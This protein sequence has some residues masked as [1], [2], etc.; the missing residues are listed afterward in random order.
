M[1]TDSDHP[2]AE[3]YLGAIDL[4]LVGGADDRARARIIRHII[5]SGPTPEGSSLW[6]TRILVDAVTEANGRFST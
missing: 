1:S 4:A 6:P 2:N 3:D 5:D